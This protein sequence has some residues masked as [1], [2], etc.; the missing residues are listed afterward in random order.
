MRNQNQL[1]PDKSKAMNRI[2]RFIWFET[3]DLAK[4]A[5][6]SGCY[7]NRIQ[8]ESDYLLRPF[9]AAFVGLPKA[10]LCQVWG[11]VFAIAAVETDAMFDVAAFVGDIAVIR[12][13]PTSIQRRC[14]AHSDQFDLMTYS[15]IWLARLD[16]ASQPIPWFLAFL[17]FLICV[18]AVL[19]TH[20]LRH[21]T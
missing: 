7:S 5:R 10:I 2:R 14:S 17:P 9:A 18:E 8:S 15:R 1:N 11:S 12:C 16:R 3:F 20:S 4:M 6:P 21:N 19:V 13:C